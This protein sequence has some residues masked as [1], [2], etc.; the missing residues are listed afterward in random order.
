MVP[1]IL[2]LCPL[3]LAA[4]FTPRQNLPEGATTLVVFQE[5]TSSE[6]YVLPEVTLMSGR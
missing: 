3:A 4:T 2:I 5:T 6:T 1:L